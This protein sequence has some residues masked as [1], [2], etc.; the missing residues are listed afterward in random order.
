MDAPDYRRHQQLWSGLHG[1]ILECP[2]NELPER[3]NIIF[4]EILDVTRVTQQAVRPQSHRH[5]ILNTEIEIGVR[6]P[7]YAFRCR[8]HLVKYSANP[9]QLTIEYRAH[10]SSVQSHFAACCSE[11]SGLDSG[12]SQ[13]L[14][15]DTVIPYFAEK[16]TCRVKRRR[17]DL[18]GALVLAHLCSI[19]PGER[20]HAW[21]C[22]EIYIALQ[23]GWLTGIRT[24]GKPGPPAATYASRLSSRRSST[25]PT[26]HRG[27]DH[28]RAADEPA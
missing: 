19:V 10:D 23:K 25:S 16:T 26:P 1:L 20:S 13:H 18:R 14:L 24:C 6:D 2:K 28:P 27:T 22:K 7:T 11:R 9:C 8:V 21:L 12:C 15:G 17:R 5:W 4:L 3:K